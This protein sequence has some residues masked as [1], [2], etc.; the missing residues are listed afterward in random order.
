MECIVCEHADCVVFCTVDSRT[1]WRCEVCLATF[2]DPSQHPTPATELAHYRRH[3]NLPGDAGYRR[4]LNRLALPLLARLT[5]ASHGLDFGCGP[6]PVLAAM[7]R[8]AGHRVAVYDPFF[9]PDPHVLA[10][11]YDFVT[12]TEVAEHFHHPA[13]SFALLDSLLRPGGWL[14]IMT[15]H[16]EDDAGFADWYYRRDPTHVVFYRDVTLRRIAARYGWRYELPAPNV[17]L[18]HKPE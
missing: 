12:C 15:T 4:F 10:Q 18:M 9:Q 7:L 14:G 16:Q 2:V 1:Y 17:S 6:G 5:P 11:S 8:E 3:E 13:A